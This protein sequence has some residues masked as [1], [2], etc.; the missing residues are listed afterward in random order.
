MN[1]PGWIPDVNIKCSVLK[2]PTPSAPVAAAFS[3]ASGILTLALTSVTVIIGAAWTDPAT[4]TASSLVSEIPSNTK[5]FL[6]SKVTPEFSSKVVVASPVPTTQGIPSSREIIEAWQVTPPSSVTIPLALLIAGTISGV[7]IVVTMMSPS[8]ILSN[9]SMS[10]TILTLPDAI[11]GLAPR[12]LTKTSPKSDASSS[13]S[14]TASPKVV[15]G[16]ACNKNNMSFSNAH[17]VSIGSP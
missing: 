15:I 9:S 14:S 3:A 10:K 4:A 17:S 13:P 2:S 6:P 1:L 11:P 7:V 16:L 5:P 8:L 12:P